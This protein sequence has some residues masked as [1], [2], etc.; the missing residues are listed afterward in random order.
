MPI[1]EYVADRCDRQPPCSRR[2]E[3]LQRVQELPLA[4]CRDCGA[5]IRRVLSSFSARSGAVGASAPDPTPLNVTGI[6]AP[7]SM[8]TGEGSCGHDH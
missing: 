5:P 2:R 4:Q 6:P 1:Y 7:S 3:Y 8:P